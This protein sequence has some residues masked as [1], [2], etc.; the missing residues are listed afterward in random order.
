M[1]RSWEV[2]VVVV[3]VVDVVVVVNTY[4]TSRVCG[5]AQVSTRHLG[6]QFTSATR[7]VV[8]PICK[9]GG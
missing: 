1:G 2:V 3:D 6:R 5:W 7:G 9:S 4:V 8:T